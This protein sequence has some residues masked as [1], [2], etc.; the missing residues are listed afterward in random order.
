MQKHMLL[1]FAEEIPRVIYLFISIVIDIIVQCYKAFFINEHTVK[2]LVIIIQVNFVEKKRTKNIS[3]GGDLQW[4]LF[5]KGTL[6]KTTFV[7][8]HRCSYA[9]ETRCSENE[10]RNGLGLINELL[11]R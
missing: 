1:R 7:Q 11:N 2:S 4:R 9:R 10:G 5:L 3:S 8:F 6:K